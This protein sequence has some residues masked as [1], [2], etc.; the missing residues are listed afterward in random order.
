MF[1]FAKNYEVKFRS[2]KGD[3]EFRN[4]FLYIV[5]TC[6]VNRNALDLAYSL[7]TKVKGM[8]AEIFVGGFQIPSVINK[9]INSGL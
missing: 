6:K 1:Q 5:T 4:V 3:E 8:V 2:E 7:I 9:L